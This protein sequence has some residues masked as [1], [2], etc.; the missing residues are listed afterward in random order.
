M[1]TI[2]KFYLL[3]AATPNTG[4]MPSGI[5]QVSGTATATTGD[6]TNARTA[7]TATDVIGTSNPD[8][9]SSITAVANTSAQSWGHRRFVSAPLAAATFASGD[10]N[11]TFSY[12]RTE[13][14]LNHNQAVRCCIYC[15]RP[16]TGAVV[17]ALGA[18]NVC[19]PVGTEPTVAGAQQ[20]ESVTATWGGTSVTIVDGDILVF[21]VTT[22]FTQLMNT[23]Y[24][25]Q[26]AY[27]GT[28][29]ASTTTCASFVTPPVALTL[30]TDYTP[31]NP[32]INYSATALLAK[33]HNAWEK[34]KGILVPRLWVPEI[35]V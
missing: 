13:S 7:R 35:T 10:G 22:F 33:A 29:E 8:L 5:L 11:W 16:S 25:E 1:A 12:A 3:D 15:W 2:S 26:F 34:R 4:T 32:G 24:T 28:T 9:E 6:A 14:N 19:T 31:R 27:D 23:A 17:V 21:D 20:A 30:F 18:S